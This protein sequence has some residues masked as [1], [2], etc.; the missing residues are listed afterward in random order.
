MS[1][2]SHNIP[3]QVKPLGNFAGNPIATILS[4]FG[5]WCSRLPMGKAKTSLNY[6]MTTSTLSNRPIRKE[7]C[8]F[9]SLATPIRYVLKLPEQSLI[10]CPSE[11]TDFVSSQMKIFCAY[12]MSIQSSQE[13]IFFMTAKDLMGIGTLEETRWNIS[14]CFWTLTRVLS[15]S[16]IVPFLFNR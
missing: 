11:S 5:K 1:Q 16:M 12:A 13:D 6:S 2:A 14:S 9:N 10:M 15:H 7:V 3:S 4:I 8:G